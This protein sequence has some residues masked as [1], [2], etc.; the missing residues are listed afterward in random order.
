MPRFMQS[1]SLVSPVFLSLWP[2]KSACLMTQT[3]HV[4]FCVYSVEIIQ[5]EALAGPVLE[6]TNN[7][8]IQLPK[9]EGFGSCV[10]SHC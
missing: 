2:V 4:S 5:E 3:S 1:V 7:E 10:E 8:T 6:E 9:N